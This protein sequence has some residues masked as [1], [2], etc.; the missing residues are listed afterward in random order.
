MGP[1]LTASCALPHLLTSPTSHHQRQF[2]GIALLEN[3]PTRADAVCTD[4]HQLTQTSKSTSEN[5]QE[6]YQNHFW[7]TIFRLKLLPASHTLT[8]FIIQKALGENHYL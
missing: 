7:V 5:P 4:R 6:T 8:E 1:S 2:A 3:L